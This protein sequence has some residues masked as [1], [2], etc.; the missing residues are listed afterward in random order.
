MESFN[1]ISLFAA[2]AISWSTFNRYCMKSLKPNYISCDDNCNSLFYGNNPLPNGKGYPLYW[3]VEET[4]VLYLKQ[5]HKEYR[6]LSDDI[7]SKIV[8]NTPTA[9]VDVICQRVEDGKLLLFL[10]RD[11]PASGVWWW[12]GGRIFKG[13]SFFDTA[14]R[15]IRDETGDHT[16]IITP[17]EVIS[18]WNTFF[19]DSNWDAGR[20]KDRYGCQTIN[21]TVLCTISGMKSSI[22]C[23]AVDAAA[24]N[25]WAVEAHKWV[26]VDEAVAPDA[27]DKYVSLNVELLK[28]RNVL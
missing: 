22:S 17:V 1:G 23:K 20:D 3:K 25:E 16:A 11:A 21:V 18:V 5:I 28:K 10:R 13:E 9:C 14:V 4:V 26:T 27:F 19:P 2:V 15:K 12:P 24:A 6:R 8:A 7:Y